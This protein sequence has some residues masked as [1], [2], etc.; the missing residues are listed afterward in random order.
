MIKLH[1]G[2][3]N[4]KSINVIIILYQNSISLA[5]SLYKYMRKRSKKIE[6]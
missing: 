6:T 1:A 5:D 3:I 4:I 2:I